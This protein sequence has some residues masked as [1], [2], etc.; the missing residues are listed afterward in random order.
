VS[1]ISDWTR[2]SKS[3]QK[4]ALQKRLVSVLFLSRSKYRKNSP[5]SPTSKQGANKFKTKQER[6]SILKNIATEFATVVGKRI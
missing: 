2:L 1:L 6:L 4:D 3:E 5:D